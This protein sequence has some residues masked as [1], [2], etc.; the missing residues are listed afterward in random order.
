MAGDLLA[1][2]KSSRYWPSLRLSRRVH[3]RAHIA[4]SWRQSHAGEYPEVGH[5]FE[6][7]P[8]SNAAPGCYVPYHADRLQHDHEVSGA[9]VSQWKLGSRRRPYQQRMNRIRQEFTLYAV[10]LTEVRV[11]GFNTRQLTKRGK[12]RSLNKFR[13]LS[14]GNCGDRISR[15]ATGALRIRPTH[16]EGFIAGPAFAA[17][18]GLDYLL[19][20]AM[21][22]TP[23][24]E[25]WRPLVP[26]HEVVG[27]NLPP[28]I[29][30]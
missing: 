20:R 17:K 26:G 28:R 25:H 12:P 4:R 8:G 9:K 13:E 1:A 3:D 2:K 5:E 7:R 29:V 27:P 22:S 19:G 15:M 18:I 24:G 6:Q 10:P 30:S 21:A 16:L 11:T 14:A 23:K